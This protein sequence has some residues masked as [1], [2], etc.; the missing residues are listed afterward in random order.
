MHHQPITLSCP[1]S[2]ASNEEMPRTPWR[3]SSVSILRRTTK[4]ILDLRDKN[5]VHD[6]YMQRPTDPVVWA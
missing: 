5:Q 1:S 4:G 2:G 6:H 3:T